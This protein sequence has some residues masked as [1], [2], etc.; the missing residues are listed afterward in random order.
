[1]S[2]EYY[3]DGFCMDNFKHLPEISRYNFNYY[4][5][6][7]G[8]LLHAKSDDDNT[9]QWWLIDGGDTFFLGLSFTSGGE[10]LVKMDE[11]DI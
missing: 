8:D 10:T 3:I 9:T 6:C 1:M 7:G 4:V 2:K 5:G 11:K